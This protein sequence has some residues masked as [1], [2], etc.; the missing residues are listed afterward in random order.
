MIKTK[1]ICIPSK[2]TFN[3]PNGLNKETMSND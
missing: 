3:V 2:V 1:F